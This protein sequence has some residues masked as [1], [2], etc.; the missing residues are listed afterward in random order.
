MIRVFLN[1]EMELCS[2]VK[3]KSVFEKYFIC[4]INVYSAVF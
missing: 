2:N 4:M 3:K 1:K